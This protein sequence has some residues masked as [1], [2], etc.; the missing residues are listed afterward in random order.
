MNTIKLKCD[1][2]SN[3]VRSNNFSKHTNSC[4]GAENLS[5]YIRKANNITK[6]APCTKRTSIMEIDWNKF[7]D[8]YDGGMSIAE[9]C[10]EF[11]TTFTSV[12]KAGKLGLI[13]TRE[14]CE[15]ARLRGNTTKGRVRPQEEKQKISASMKRAVAEGRQRTTKPYGVA[16]FTYKE[17]VLQSKWELKVAL[18]LD[19]HNIKWERPMT[20]HEY[21]FDDATHLYFPDFYLPDYNVYIEVKGWKQLKDECKWRDFKHTLKVIDSKS[22]NDLDRFFEKLVLPEG[23]EPPTKELCIP[24]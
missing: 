5:W 11:K 12:S 13:K 18:H 10:K 22:I 15:T 16:C 6:D 23:F 2:C 4:T 19:N 1:K 7:Q 20:G 9:C 17:V 14:R 21:I 24:L 8:A 3:L